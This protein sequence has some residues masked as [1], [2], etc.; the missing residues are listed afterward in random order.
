[1]E[2]PSRTNKLLTVEKKPI[3]LSIPKYGKTPFHRLYRRTSIYQ[4]VSGHQKRK[5]VLGT[6]SMPIIFYKGK[7]LKKKKKGTGISLT[8]LNGF[9]RTV[10]PLKEKNIKFSIQYMENLLDEELSK[11]SNKSSLHFRLGWQEL[12]KAHLNVKDRMKE[13]YVD[14][15]IR[16]NIQSA[17]SFLS[18][19]KR[20]ISFQWQKRFINF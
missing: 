3:V 4:S 1:M 16:K 11:N 19:M 18:L 14:E 10:H 8:P 17:L 9:R 6:T 12:L 20:A 5:R 2:F 15:I 13:S 7:R